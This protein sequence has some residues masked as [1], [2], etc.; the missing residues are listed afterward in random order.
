MVDN[1]SLNLFP[2]KS[3]RRETAMV[4]VVHPEAKK[5]LKQNKAKKLILPLGLMSGGGILLYYGIKAPTKSRI[6][7]NL[8]NDRI[9]QMDSNLKV[10]CQAVDDTISESYKKFAQYIEKYSKEHNINLSADM[11]TNLSEPNKV[12]KAQDLAF[13]AIAPISNPKTLG[14]LSGFAAF[15]ADMNHTNRAVRETLDR[16]QEL[17]RLLFDD[18][19]KLPENPDESLNKLLLS[20]SALLKSY[21]TDILGQMGVNKFMKLK[22]A[23]SGYYNQMAQAVVES[24][25]HQ[26][27]TKKQIIDASYAKASQLL[28]LG[29]DLTP[30]YNRL[31]SLD[32]YNN[33]TPQELKPS[34]V[35][36]ELNDVFGGNIYFKRAAAKDFNKITDKDIYNLFYSAY[37]D[38]NLDDLKFLID[39]LRLR[40]V[41][42]QSSSADDAQ[43]YKVLIAKLEFMLN[44]MQELGVEEIVKF[45][46]KDFSKM[47]MEQKRAALYYVS[48]ASRRMG[49]NTIEDMDKFMAEKSPE[50]SKLNIR[51]YMELFK[52]NPELYFF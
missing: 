43:G 22:K 9:S 23:V 8:V 1:L 45:S 37:Y 32:N 21:S 38:N 20:S 3:P 44:K 51:D 50:Y 49:F 40:Q 19:I 18:Y 29:D 25:N 14:G 17:M 30:A 28:G 4:S 42:V 33:L 31:P 36:K 12:I 16:K 6:I 52:K 24:R 39:R 13:D 46:S 10:Y 48:T 47:N 15:S 2:N 41:I 34:A 35:S 26:L 5:D 7:K 11:F 27:N